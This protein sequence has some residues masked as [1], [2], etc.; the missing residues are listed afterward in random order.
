MSTRMDEASRAITLEEAQYLIMCGMVAMSLV[1][2]RFV[3]W[4]WAE[5]WKQWRRIFSGPREEDDGD[6]EEDEWKL[7]ATVDPTR[8]PQPAVSSKPSFL[9]LVPSAAFDNKDNNKGTLVDFLQVIMS[10]AAS[11]SLH[12]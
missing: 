10:I 5:W 9:N 3:D 8:L 4:R 7:E 11:I 2:L 12:C 1:F 6:W